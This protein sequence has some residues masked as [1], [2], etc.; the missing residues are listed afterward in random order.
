MICRGLPRSLRRHPQTLTTPA[1]WEH[2]FTRQSWSETLRQ[3]IP[4]VKEELAKAYP[5]LDF[6]TGELR[7]WL[8]WA[9]EFAGDHA[10]AQESWRQSRSELDSFLK[11]QPENWTLIEDLALIDAGLGDKTAALALLQ[12]A[13]AAVPVEKDALDGPVPIEILAR[14]AAQVGEPDRAISALHKL[15]SIPSPSLQHH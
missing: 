1:L 5:A 9:Q 11:E 6:H 15:L 8:G 13:T 2:E 12:R 3:I 7:L 10:G 4:R 14:V